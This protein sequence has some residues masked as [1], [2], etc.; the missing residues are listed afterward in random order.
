VVQNAY[1]YF[2]L[3]GVLGKNI[4]VGA[5]G[6]VGL[7]AGMLAVVLATFGN[8]PMTKESYAETTNGRTVL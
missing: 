6:L 5:F 3:Q 4:A 8:P 2:S 1:F 7:A